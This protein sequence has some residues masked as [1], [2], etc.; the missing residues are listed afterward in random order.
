MSSDN[1]GDTLDSPE[2]SSS[3]P[4]IPESHIYKLPNEVL[5]KIFALLPSRSRRRGGLHACCLVSKRFNYN[6]TPVLYRH[7]TLT[8]KVRAGFLPTV[9]QSF[10][11]VGHNRG[12]RYVRTL[13]IRNDSFEAPQ[14]DRYNRDRL[15]DNIRF[16]IEPMFKTLNQDQMKFISL[17]SLHIL[18]FIPLTWFPKIK[19]L[20]YGIKWA[21]S[22]F[23]DNPIWE[24]TVVETFKKEATRFCDRPLF[25]LLQNLNTLAISDIDMHSLGVSFDWVFQAGPNL[26]AL[27]LIA[28][29]S[30]YRLGVSK[31]MDACLAEWESSKE[32]EENEENE[33]A[34]EPEIPPRVLDSLK[35]RKIEFLDRVIVPLKRLVALEELKT[36]DVHCCLFSNNLLNSELPKM[37]NLTDLSLSLVDRDTCVSKLLQSLNPCLHTL[38]LKLGARHFDKELIPSIATHAN[39]LVKLWLEHQY[40]NDGIMELERIPDLPT[41][42][43]WAGKRPH[44]SLLSF[45]DVAEFPVLK[46]LAMTIG[47]PRSLHLEFYGCLKNLQSVHVLNSPDYINYSLAS[48]EHARLPSNTSAAWFRGHAPL[49]A[50]WFNGRYSTRTQEFWDTFPLKVISFKKIYLNSQIIPFGAYMQRPHQP[51]QFMFG[52]TLRDI[53]DVGVYWPE[54]REFLGD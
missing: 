53:A 54:V 42:H 14:F 12:L 35:L 9:I 25:P 29:N 26:K 39:T 32:T 28:L 3:S 48:L 41:D 19:E 16:V 4:P 23:L 27:N 49:W 34:K 2:L 8:Y 52:G 18:P 31:T 10:V 7:L 44:P 20:K 33:E 24:A 11:Q 50:Q 36:L 17:D 45:E 47:P 21:H 37:K 38:R 43:E 15:M 51:G 40:F 1:Q 13:E 30:R 46:H 5:L 22:S 6:A